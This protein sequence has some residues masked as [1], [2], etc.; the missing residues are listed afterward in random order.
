MSQETQVNTAKREP[1]WKR[2]KPPAKVAQVAAL[3]AEGLDEN[4]IAERLGIGVRTV[5]LYKWRARRDAGVA[6]HQKSIRGTLAERLAA[7]LDKSGPPHPR[8]GTPCW[9]HSGGVTSNGEYGGIWDTRAEVFPIPA[10]IP[11]HRAAWALATGKPLDPDVFIMHKCDTPRCCNPEH[12][13]AG[14]PMDNMRDAMAKGRHVSNRSAVSEDAV[15]EIR[16][17]YDAGEKTVDIAKAMRL[18]LEPVWRAATRRSWK[19]V[20]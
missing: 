13:Q 15:R 18:P 9:I 17:R 1:R 20:T 12:L 4:T 6:K 11:A 5:R 14:T 7:K 19:H 8:L 3:F 2:A 10:W 16:R